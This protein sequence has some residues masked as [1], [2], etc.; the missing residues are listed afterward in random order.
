MLHYTDRE[1]KVYIFTLD[2]VLE[3][4]IVE[5]LS[6]EL[7]FRAVEILTPGGGKE[8]ITVED[9]DKLARDSL[10]GRLIIMD[11][12]SQT[13]PTL[14]AVFNKV[15][16]YNRADLN[17]YCYM[18]L[19]GDGPVGFFR[20]QISLDTFAPHL[21]KMRIDCNAALYFYDPLLHYEYD[22]KRH[23]GIDRENQLLE[24]I[25]KRLEKAFEGEKTTVR[26]LRP[27]FRAA[28]AK[29]KKKAVKKEKRQRKL[30]KLFTKSTINGSRPEKEKFLKSLS[31]KGYEIKG[32]SLRL[33]VY[34]FFFE[35]WAK[36]LLKK[37][38]ASVG[39][40]S[41]GD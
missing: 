41:S 24:V 11:M 14:Q 8:N 20:D 13:Q 21:A 5:R 2:S 36:R 38:R 16:C 18:I 27:Y 33:N 28:K 23:L 39:I 1:D 32:E 26:D 15:V 6:D 10:T 35:R 25:P 22:E 3:L 19:I 40:K 34:P 30:A 31:R 9:N 37:A 17:R 12:R 29:G 4:D 7:G